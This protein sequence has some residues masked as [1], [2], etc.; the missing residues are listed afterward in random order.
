MVDNL[1]DRAADRWHALH[2]KL[3]ETARER[4]ILEKAMRVVA[5]ALYFR[6]NFSMHR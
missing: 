5:V 3:E 4:N 2:T 1:A 6:L